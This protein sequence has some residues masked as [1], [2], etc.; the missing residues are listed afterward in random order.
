M[1]LESLAAFKTKRYI[2]EVIFIVSSFWVISNL[3]NAVYYIKLSREGYN[4]KYEIR[5][6]KR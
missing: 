3:H 6:K 1:P 5:I 4:I 2:L